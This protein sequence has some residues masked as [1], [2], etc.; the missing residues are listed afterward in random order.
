LVIADIVLLVTVV[1]V[2]VVRVAAGGNGFDLVIVWVV[3]SIR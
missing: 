3:G 1:M 2:T